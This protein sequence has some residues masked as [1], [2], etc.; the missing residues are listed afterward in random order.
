M[1]EE[2]KD[3]PAPVPNN[4][5]PVWALVVH[6]M[7][8]RDA[9]GRE[10]Y[11]TPLQAYNGRDPLVD[12]YQ[13][14]LDQAVYLRQAIVERRTRPRFQGERWADPRG[15]LWTY[16]GLTPTGLCS[17]SRPKFTG[18]VIAV[19]DVERA[20][21]FYPEALPHREAMAEEI[22]RL[23]AREVELLARNTE[24]VKELRKTDRERM[25]REFMVTMN[26]PQ[27]LGARPHVPAD[28]VIRFRMGLVAEEVIETVEACF[29]DSKVEPWHIQRLK[30]EFRWVVEHCPIQ[31]DM[32]ELVDGTID[33]DYV[34]EGFRLALGVS[35]TALWEEVQ[36]ANLDKLNGPIREGD[37][38]QLKPDGWKPPDIRGRLIA[39]G[40][41]P[42]KEGE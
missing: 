23:R 37:G 1:N 26:P 32:V 33:T 40:W 24:L 21:L 5:A 12:S 8:E 2:P 41:V 14:A 42:P 19:E 20:W 4:N 35:S 29:K 6:D 11:G 34:M 13:E 28:S 17:F 31:I 30:E 22:R 15:V 25:V 16:D 9:V 39:Q 3:Q 38:K 27:Y 7:H 36:R 10:R 18:I